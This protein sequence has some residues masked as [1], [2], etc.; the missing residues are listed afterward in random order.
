MVNNL[1]SIKNMSKIIKGK[2]VLSNITLDFE[3]GKIYGIVGDNGSGKTMLLRAISRFL[4]P[5]S[6]ELVF[7][8]KNI[9][10]GVIIENPGFLP[11]YT[12]F[13][14]LKLLAQIRNVIGDFEI[15]S[16]MERVGLDPDDKR[17]VK[18]YSLGMRQK[19]AI[20][21][22][23]MENPTLLVLDEPF[24]GLDEKSV[25]LV[26][27]LL[28]EYNQKGGTVLLTSHNTDEDISSICHQVYKIRNGRI[29]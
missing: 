28:L 16:S 15:R 8:T 24:R 11:N 22:A 2:V 6:G 23:I 17:K 25:K 29:V 10:M 27:Q 4:T 19:L 13:E 12:G 20:A 3:Y 1:I 5:T 18:S 7:S 26:R 9:T 21:Q 14:N